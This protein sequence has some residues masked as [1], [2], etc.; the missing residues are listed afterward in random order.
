MALLPLI[1]CA[2]LANYLLR[3]V[4]WHYSLFRD[5]ESNVSAGIKPADLSVG[6]CIDNGAWQAR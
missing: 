5:W 3:F 4:R 1:V 2:V 6:L